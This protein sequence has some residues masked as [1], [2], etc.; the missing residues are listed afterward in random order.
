M[1]KTVLFAALF[2]ALN[3]HAQQ[4]ASP[5]AKP[6]T[7]LIVTGWRETVK[8]PPTSGLTRMEAIHMGHV[9]EESGA[10]RY[11]REVNPTGS[12][13]PCFGSTAVLLFEPVT[14]RD[15]KLHQWVE[16]WN[17]VCFVVHEV[18]VVQGDS[19]RLSGVNNRYSD[20]WVKDVCG[21]VCA[22]LI[23]DSRLHMDPKPA[24]DG[25]AAR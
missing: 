5:A 22:V 19:I 4:S 13:L 21:R 25:K 11:F 6:P 8:P 9:W 14:I 3:A 16:Y 7:K 10:G 20:P 2:A 24:A 1:K 18:T 12:M 15:V 17:G 23:T